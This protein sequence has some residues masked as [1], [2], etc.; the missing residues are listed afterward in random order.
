MTHVKAVAIGLLGASVQGA[1]LL[2][3]K[4]CVITGKADGRPSITRADRDAGAP[5]KSK[6]G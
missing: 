5:S 4:D 3:K 6:R 1:A 2:Q